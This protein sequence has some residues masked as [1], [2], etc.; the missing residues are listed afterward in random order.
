MATTDFYRDEKPKPGES[1]GSTG[2]YWGTGGGGGSDSSGGGGWGSGGGGSD[3]GS[4]GSGGGSGGGSG[5]E[6][7][8]YLIG[9]WDDEGEDLIVVNA[10]NVIMSDGTF[11]LKSAC[12]MHIEL[13]AQIK[14]DAQAGGFNHYDCIIWG[15]VGR[16]G[17]TQSNIFTGLLRN[18]EVD[19]YAYWQ[20]GHYDHSEVNTIRFRV[21]DMS[22]TVTPWYTIPIGKAPG[23]RVMTLVV[24]NGI[25][26]VKNIG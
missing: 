12:C 1:G 19:I 22:N 4:D 26:T 14:G 7:P 2:G 17:D 11:L 10:E 24:R 18:G 21:K 13:E 6:K 16:E 23:Q 25:L 8:W 20:K 9:Y 3:G 5:A 15:A